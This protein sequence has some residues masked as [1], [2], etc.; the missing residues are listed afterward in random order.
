MIAMKR[1]P[2]ECIMESHDQQPP[3]QPAFPAYPGYTAQPPPQPI[4]Q[5]YGYDT[6]SYGPPVGVPQTS[7]FAIASLICSIAGWFLVPFIGGVL[8]VIFGHIARR[9]IRQSQGWK[10]GDGLALA[11]LIIG[12]IH[13]TLVVLAVAALILLAIVFAANSNRY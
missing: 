3:G 7:G 2:L 5:P 9:E 13:I 10:S 12:Y 11:G 1:M 6:P 4:A 8:G